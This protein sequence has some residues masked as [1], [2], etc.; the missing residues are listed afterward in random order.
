MG[1]EITE[2]DRKH[3]QGRQKLLESF[4]AEDTAKKKTLS[5]SLGTDIEGSYGT[6]EKELRSTLDKLAELAAAGK[7]TAKE[8][9]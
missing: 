6:I 7:K 2:I 3:Y 4:V 1:Q 9:V 5:A 8:N